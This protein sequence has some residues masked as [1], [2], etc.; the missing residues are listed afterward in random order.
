MDQLSVFLLFEANHIKKAKTKENADISADY[1]CESINAIF[2]LS[3]FLNSLK[4]ADARPLHKKG[5]KELNEDY[6]S[7]SILPTSS[8]LF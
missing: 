2:K 4:L 3:M 5:R 7:I 6:R 8:N 1:L